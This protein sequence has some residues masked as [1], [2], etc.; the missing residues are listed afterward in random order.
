MVTEDRRQP[1]GSG[2]NS[3]SAAQSEQEVSRVVL[4]GTSRTRCPWPGWLH[5]TQE[6]SGAPRWSSGSG[7]T[8]VIV[9]L[10]FCQNSDA[11]LAAISLTP[12]FVSYAAATS[13]T[14]SL[15]RSMKT[16]R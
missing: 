12:A 9:F 8:L 10:G 16:C 4:P 7:R 5:F 14:S 2:T 3:Q 13:A 15:H 6:R 1:F 11:D